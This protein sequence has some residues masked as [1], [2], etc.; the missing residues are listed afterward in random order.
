MLVS[1]NMWSRP[2]SAWHNLRFEGIEP[3]RKLVEDQSDSP[4]VDGRRIWLTI[5]DLGGCEQGGTPPVLCTKEVII[6]HNRYSKV[7][8]FPDSGVRQRLDDFQLVRS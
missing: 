6:F 3:S 4:D 7:S 1:T 5:E 2:S 8:D